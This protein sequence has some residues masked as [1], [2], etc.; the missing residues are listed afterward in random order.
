ME[1][2]L[3]FS[4]P[5]VL[6]VVDNVKVSVSSCPFLMPLKRRRVFFRGD[7]DFVMLLL[8]SRESL[9]CGRSYSLLCSDGT[10]GL[11]IIPRWFYVLAVKAF[12][13]VELHPPRPGVSD[14][15]SSCSRI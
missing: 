12:L 1:R 7:A 2:V 11:L 15:R 8:L 13:D 10:C 9:F 14:P 6:H 4:W 3:Y 5:L